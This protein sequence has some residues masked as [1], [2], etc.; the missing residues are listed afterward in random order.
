MEPQNLYFYPS[1]RHGPTGLLARDLSARIM[2]SGKYVT[3]FVGTYSPG[4]HLIAE[5]DSSVYRPEP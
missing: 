2:V 1:G 3:R 4:Y 5:V